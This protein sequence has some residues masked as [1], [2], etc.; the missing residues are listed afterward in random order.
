M[1][2]IYSGNLIFIIALNILFFFL[3]IFLNSLVIISFWRSVQ[4]RKKLCYFMIMV[5]SC[6]DLLAVLTSHPFTILC[7]M[8]WL[9][10]KFNEYPKWIHNSLRSSAVFVAFSLNALA[11]M[12]FDRYLATS[13]AIFHRTSVT[14]AKLLTCLALLNIVSVI[15]LLL[16]FNDF[17]LSY[18]V[19]I[20]ICFNI[21]FPSMLAFNYKLFK[22][23]RKSRRNNKIAPETKKSFSLKNVSSCVLAVACFVVLF[24]PL[25]AYVGL[26]QF[27]NEKE[28]TKLTALWATTICSMNSTCNCLIF[29]WKRKILRTE[30]MKVIKSIEVFRKFYRMNK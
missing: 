2:L 14:K 22:A 9:I 26:R 17:I 1:E 24:T 7:G 4:L 28:V 3:G 13:Y 15:L 30:G 25:L 6:C 10:E 27:S 21:Y 19:C 11:V 29:Y 16:S 8:L 5:L 18:E 12:S 20:L 23:A